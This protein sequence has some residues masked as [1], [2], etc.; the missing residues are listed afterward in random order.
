[1]VKLEREI[2]NLRSLCEQIDALRQ[3]TIYVVP[4]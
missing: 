2:R 3:L 4:S 1:L